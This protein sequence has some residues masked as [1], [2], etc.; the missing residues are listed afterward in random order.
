MKTIRMC[1]S[2]YTTHATNSK[3][4]T[5][6]PKFET[7]RQRK[8]NTQLLH[9]FYVHETVSTLLGCYLSYYLPPSSPLPL[10]SYAKCTHITL[11]EAKVQ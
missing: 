6:L 5:L 3:S 10:S 1:K 7:L 2:F 4:K 9:V 11:S 8:K